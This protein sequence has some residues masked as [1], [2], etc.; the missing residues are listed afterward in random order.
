[1][2]ELRTT[3]DEMSLD[4]GFFVELLLRC[5]ATT[6]RVSVVAVEFVRLGFQY[7]PYVFM[8]RL[9]KSR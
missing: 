7:S 2:C 6:H 8:K 3:N 4:C 1:M 5:M 9:H